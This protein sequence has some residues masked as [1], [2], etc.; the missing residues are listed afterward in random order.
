MQKIHPKHLFLKLCGT[1]HFEA[2]MFGLLFDETA[3]EK[4]KIPS[5][6]RPVRST[7]AYRVMHQAEVMHAGLVLSPVVFVTLCSNKSVQRSALRAD[8]KA[9]FAWNCNLHSSILC[10]PVFFCTNNAQEH[11]CIIYFSIGST[12]T[13]D[14]IG[15]IAFI[16]MFLLESRLRGEKKASFFPT[17]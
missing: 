16:C 14:Q 17:Q 2:I 3:V 12:T 7:L 6:V 10:I 11:R 9:P 13:D 4:R 8:S 1:Y 5:H 15:L